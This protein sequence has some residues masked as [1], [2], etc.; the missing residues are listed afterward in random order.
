MHSRPASARRLAGF[1]DEIDALPQLVD[2][3]RVQADQKTGNPPQVETGQAFARDADA[4]PTVLSTAF[5]NDSENRF[6]RGA[7][8]SGLNPK[9]HETA[10]FEPV[11]DR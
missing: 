4:L 10:T 3:Y 5:V 11:R 7:L 6:E 8:R 2:L 1:F 9:S